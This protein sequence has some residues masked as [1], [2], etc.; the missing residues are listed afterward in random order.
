MRSLDDGLARDAQIFNFECFM[1]NDNAAN[2]TLIIQHSSFVRNRHRASL[3]S[4]RLIHR[5]SKKQRGRE[6]FSDSV[7]AISDQK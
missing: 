2:S 6:S 5:L 3:A 4:Y 1:F 7:A